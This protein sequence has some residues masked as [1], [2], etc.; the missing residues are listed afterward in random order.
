MPALD[1][2]TNTSPQDPPCDILTRLARELED[3]EFREGLAGLQGEWGHTKDASGTLAAYMRAALDAAYSEPTPDID[4]A[5]AED[6]SRRAESEFAWRIGRGR[7]GGLRR[8]VDA[9]AR[10]EKANR[11]LAAVKHQIDPPSR[12]TEI[13]RRF[14]NRRTSVRSV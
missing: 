10:A 9:W 14:P 11:D 8:C 5:T 7:N 6:R 3:A 2:T 4:L 12:R 1:D 13:V